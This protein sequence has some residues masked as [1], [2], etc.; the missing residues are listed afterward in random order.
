M[1]AKVIEKAAT[2]YSYSIY[3]EAGSISGSC[4]KL[5]DVFKEIM[6]WADFCQEKNID[7]YGYEIDK[8]SWPDWYE[9]QPSPKPKEKHLESVNF[10]RKKQ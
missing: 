6:D 3:D 4:K 1:T 8:L 7:F 10:T 2:V 9:G 5:Q